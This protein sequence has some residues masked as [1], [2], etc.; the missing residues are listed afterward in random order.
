MSVFGP[1]ARKVAHDLNG[2][3]TTIHANTSALSDAV[4]ALKAAL[5]ESTKALTPAEKRQFFARHHVDFWEKEAPEITAD[6]N[7]AVAS[8]HELATHLRTFAD[9]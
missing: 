6:I 2:S 8:L 9:G 5:D 3:L 7:A 4:Q 1:Q